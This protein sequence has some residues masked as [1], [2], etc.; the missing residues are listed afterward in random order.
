M[1]YT[2]TQDVQEGF[3][4]VNMARACC[5]ITVMDIAVTEGILKYPEYAIV[6][7]TQTVTLALTLTLNF[8]QILS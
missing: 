3:V 1:A 4:A 2:A 7:M 6:G 8:T 5:Q